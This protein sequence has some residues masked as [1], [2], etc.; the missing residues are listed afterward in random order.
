MAAKLSFKLLAFILVFVHIEG[1]L[2]CRAV[3][4][5]KKEVF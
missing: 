2:R 1:M 4:S 5:N 3:R